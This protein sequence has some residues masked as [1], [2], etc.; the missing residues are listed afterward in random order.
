MA[1]Y[2]KTFAK[3]AGGE[4]SIILSPENEYLRQFRG[5]RSGIGIGMRW[6]MALVDC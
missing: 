6:I 3:S 4:S 1:S 5:T 2:D